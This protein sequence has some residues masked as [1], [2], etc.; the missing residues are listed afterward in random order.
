MRARGMG[1]DTGFRV[2]GATGRTLDRAQVQRELQIIRD[3]LHCN[4]VRLIG[5]DLDRLEV[6]AEEAAGLGLE[7][8][9]SPYPM[10]LDPQEILELLADGAER[11]E[12]LRR[13]GAAVVF[14]AGAE[15]SLFDKGFLPGVSIAERTTGLLNRDPRTMT[16]LAGLPGRVNAFLA[17][18]VGVVRDRFGGKVTYAAVPLE[19][20]DWQPFDIVS[21]DLHRSKEIAHVYRQGVRQLVAQGKPVAITEVGCAT[22]RGAS[23]HAARGGAIVEYDG[24]TPVRLKGHYIRD[25]QEQATYLRELL[26]LFTAEGVDAAFVCTFIQYHLPHRE[27]PGRDLDLGSVGIVKALDDGLGQTYPDVPWEPKAAFRAVASAYGT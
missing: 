15:L 6:A 3:D 24:W 9:F 8:W 4:A 17:E 2:G 20:V 5:N 11:A 22:Y 16:Q 7:V 27:D 19:G 13:R 12:R 1:Y 18:A 25:E 21:V 14:V 26:D 23:D 10:E